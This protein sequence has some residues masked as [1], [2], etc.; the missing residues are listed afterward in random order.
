MIHA[1]LTIDDIAS[2]N[3]RPFVDYLLE[4][5]IP[6]IMFAWGK[7]VEENYE[8]ALYAVKNGIIVGNHS[9]SHPFFSKLT[10]E[11]AIEEIEKNEAILDKL[12]QDA[13]VPRVYRPF[14]FP[15][16]DKGGE[17]KDALQKYFREHGFHKVKDDQIPYAVWKEMGLDKDIDTFWTYDFA[18]YMIRPDSGVT[19]DD[20]LKRTT[21]VNPDLGLS[22]LSDKNGSHLIIIHAHDE[23]EELVPQYY[24]T[25]IDLL[26]DNGFVFDEPQFYL[27]SENQ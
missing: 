20:I 7:R 9:Y 26:L 5:K 8:N 25:L 1:V 24:R 6:A 27:P 11:E 13:G 3:T 19:M 23:T 18:E 12:Y 15:Y 16:G 4:K 22:L 10:M 17:N 2:K 21:Q 14:R